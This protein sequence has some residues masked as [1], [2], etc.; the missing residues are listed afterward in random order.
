MTVRAESEEQMTIGEAIKKARKD[1][2]WTQ[3]QL[4]AESGIHFVLISL[5]ETG[6]VFPGVLTLISIADALGVTLDALVGRKVAN[7]C[8]GS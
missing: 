1:K 3:R 7:E 8:A 2:G 6:R 4:A 5:Y